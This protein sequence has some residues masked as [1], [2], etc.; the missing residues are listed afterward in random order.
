M[1]AS[2]LLYWSIHDGMGVVVVHQ[3]TF[4]FCEKW[5]HHYFFFYFPLKSLYF[6]FLNMIV[7]NHYALLFNFSSFLNLKYLYTA[8]W[9]Q[10]LLM[11]WVTHFWRWS[12]IGSDSLF[13]C[14]LAAFVSSELEIYW[15]SIKIDIQNKSS[16]LKLK[17]SYFVIKRWIPTRRISTSVWLIILAQSF[18]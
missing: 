12:I 8:Y 11:R 3:G 13:L 15:H 18:K 1:F 17:S 7:I 2:V 10:L 14:F 5:T 6:I 9:N 16:G 4:Y